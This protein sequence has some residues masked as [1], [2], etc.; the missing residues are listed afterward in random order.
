MFVVTTIP[1]HPFRA[2]GVCCTC[3]HRV[4]LR[5]GVRGCTTCT[6]D[7]P[8]YPIRGPRVC[9]TRPP[10]SSI[11]SG[12]ESRD[13]PHTTTTITSVVRPTRRELRR[14]TTRVRGHRPSS[15]PVRD[16]GVY[17]TSPRSREHRPPRPDWRPD[18]CHG[19]LRSLTVYN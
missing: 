7:H 8:P 10:S 2:P 5:A 1:S 13:L 12:S 4:S 15:H 3:N 18:V 19:R 6:H 17:Y 9:W 14:V 11:R 16:P